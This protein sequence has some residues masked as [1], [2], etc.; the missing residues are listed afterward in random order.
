M[1]VNRVKAVA[2]ITIFPCPFFHLSLTSIDVISSYVEQPPNDHVPIEDPL[3]IDSLVPLFGLL[4]PKSYLL[5]IGFH[6]HISPSE[7]LY[8]IWACATSYIKVDRIGSEM[9]CKSQRLI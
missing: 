9:L 4:Y 5:I 1:R 7:V 2:E 8:R 3:R 6:M